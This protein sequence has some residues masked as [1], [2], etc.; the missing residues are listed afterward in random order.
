MWARTIGGILTYAGVGGFL[1]NLADVQLDADEDS[2]QW[3]QFLR[4]I[5][6]I[7]G[8]REFTTSDLVGHLFHTRD[9][10]S[11]S[12]PDEIGH[13]E[14]RPNDGTVSFQRRLGKALARK[15]ETRFGDLG[16]RIEKRKPDTHTKLQ[17][18]AVAGNLD[19]LIQQGAKPA[20]F[21]EKE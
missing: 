7:L 12:L 2:Q 18:W 14:E 15:C 1:E 20:G 4:A 8:G 11:E 16:L 9:L 21:A 3:E 19:S 6:L 17:R 13:P 10:L 5:V